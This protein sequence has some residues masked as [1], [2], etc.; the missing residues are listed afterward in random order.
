MQTFILVPFLRPHTTSW[1]PFLPDNSCF[2]QTRLWCPTR[3]LLMSHT[4]LRSILLRYNLRTIKCTHSERTVQSSVADV[5]TRVTTSTAKIWNVSI[6]PHIPTPPSVLA[7]GNRFSAFCHSRLVL[8]FQEFHINGIICHI[9]SFYKINGKARDTPLKRTGIAEMQCTSLA[10][11][12]DAAWI[13]DSHPAELPPFPASQPP[14]APFCVA[15]CIHDHS[16][17][18]LLEPC[19][20]SW[21]TFA[22]WESKQQ[23]KPLEEHLCRR[24]CWS[25]GRTRQEVCPLSSYWHPR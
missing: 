7:W 19:F 18:S 1:I 12:P 25:L 21:T 16:L 23:M 5:C 13:R 22:D 9:L 3:G 14:S 15:L 17:P 24:G 11:L 2:C 6:T 10:S 20:P 4:F 8:P